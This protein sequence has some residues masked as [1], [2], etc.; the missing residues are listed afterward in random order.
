VTRKAQGFLLYSPQ[1]LRDRLLIGL[2]AVAVAVPAHALDPHRAA[3]QY[4]VTRWGAG[5]LPGNAV[6]ALLQ[7]RD[8]HLWLGTTTGLARF[9][10]AAFTVFT[11]KNTPSFGDGGATRLTEGVDGTLFVGTSAGTVLRHERGTFTRLFVPPGT[12]NVSALLAAR[13]GSVWIG[14]YGQLL[15]QWKAGQAHT[16]AREVAIQ[17]PRALAEH[18]GDLY[19]GTRERGLVSYR[20]GVFRRHEV[21]DDVI[22]ALCFDREGA[23][24]IGTPHGLL[25][26]RDGAVETF[27]RKDGL[28]S[29]SVSA[30]LEDRDGNI[31]VGTAGGG[32]NRL[33]HGRWTRLTTL[34]GL[35]DDDVRCLLEDDEGNLWVGTAD[36]LNCLSDGRFTTYGRFEGLIDPAVR[37]VVPGADGSVWVGTSSGRVARLRDGT[38]EHFDLPGGVGQDAVIAMH[39]AKDGGLWVAVDNNRLFRVAGGRVT[40]RT[41]QG[42]E[43]VQSPR[44][45]YEDDD[46]GLVVLVTALG[47]TRLEGRRAVPIEGTPPIRYPHAI[48]KGADGTL[49]VG[50]LHGLWRIRGR[51]KRLFTVK[52]GLP[53]NRVRSL[54]VDG[55]GVWAATIGG[56]AYFAGD[57]ARTLTTADG[58]PENYLRL[59]LDDGRG[60]L[61]I[62]SSGSLF[63]VEKRELQERLAGR[64]G[65]VSPVVFDTFDGLRSTEGLLA[66]NAGFRAPDGRLWFAT[67]KGVSV[68]DPSRINI[69]DPG[70]RVDVESVAVD[71]RRER[72]AEYPPG[73]GEVTIDFA[74]LLFRAPAKVRFRYRLDG[75][76]AAWVPAGTRRSAYYSNLPPGRYQFSAMASNTDGVWNGPKTSLTFS[77]RPPF[78]STPLFYASAAALALLVGA[79]VYRVRV[80]Q[81]RAR[82]AVIISERTRIARELHDTLAQGLAAVALQIETAVESLSEGTQ[83]AREHM[84]LADRM[85]RSSLDE[86]RRSIWVLRAQTARGD[87]GVGVTLSRSLA[88]LTADTDLE[89]SIAVTGRVRPLSTELERNLLRI[90]HEAVT[91]AVRH[92]DARRITIELAFEP[93]AV[94]LR[95]QDDGCG[96]DAEEQARRRGAH[97]GLTGIS[98]RARAVGG[99]VRL[100][101]AP[102]RGTEV[103]CHLPYHSRVD[104]SE[105]ASDDV[106]G[107]SL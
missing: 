71:G 34:E 98:E 52:D 23:L 48:E 5:A 80:G 14:M 70:P 29:E 21:T 84:R 39:E 45:F 81:M 104:L 56:L 42:L 8:R 107:I 49:W 90:A 6:H 40:E 101:T 16:F 25:R 50:D 75:F 1:M 85:V 63:R 60:Y 77:I 86:V 88:Q 105:A 68:V 20:D 69:G 38:V 94:Q 106:E 97:F 66:N 18:G 89:S 41:P 59:V 31:W 44:L 82:F 72:Q 92:A 78:T 9:D 62:A 47:L 96:F 61:W 55:D 30:I 22:Q 93:D 102:G 19:I 53:A 10:G 12:A 95:V 32:L 83:A 37:S 99:E 74:A 2:F 100:T 28:S 73:R 27:T 51:D 91:N 54:S 13:D 57:R 79:A 35:T 7:T 65:Q 15:H 3:S 64:P 58:L 4:V 11:G 46:R 36:G 26:Y 17:A 87:E 76:D 24:W 33:T 43:R 67:A 103:V